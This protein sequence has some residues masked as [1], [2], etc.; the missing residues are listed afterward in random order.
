MA[1]SAVSEGGLVREVYGRA[2]AF[3]PNARVFPAAARR[4]C[5]AVLLCVLLLASGG[6]RARAPRSDD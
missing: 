4:R 3:H 6:P 1:C 2:R 5:L